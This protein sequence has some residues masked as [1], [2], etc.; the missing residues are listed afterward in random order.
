VLLELLFSPRGL[1]RLMPVFALGAV[2][3][4]LLYRRGRKAEALLIA[5]V[6]AL[7]LGYDTGFI[8]PFGG[9]GPGPRYLM[10]MLPFLAVPLALA[11]R[12]LPV[13][14]TALA[15]VSVVWM[16]AA[17]ATEPLLPN[18]FFKA[19]RRGDIADTGHWFHRAADGDFTRTVLT[20]AGAGHGWIGIAPF[21]LAV[22]AGLLLA[23]LA[24]GPPRIRWN[25]AEAAAV[26]LVG[27]L[28]AALTGPVLLRH[29]RAT[30]SSLGALA[31][32]ALVVCVIVTATRVNRSGVLAVLPALPL[33]AFAVH[34]FGYHQGWALL[35]ALA[36]LVVS[37]ALEWRALRSWAGRRSGRV[38]YR[39]DE[40]A[41]GRP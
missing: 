33:L 26:A 2:G 10:P 16:V 12:R 37:L 17:T 14:T 5:G 19:A 20:S 3:I 35:L 8:E 23:A 6:C 25:E 39:R 4:V 7:I 11:Y 34:R 36:V 1:L 18:N 41:R 13:T 32:V 21:L 22:V 38:H 28:L 24:T 31:L 27:W 29:D 30:G 40:P 15:L 9:W